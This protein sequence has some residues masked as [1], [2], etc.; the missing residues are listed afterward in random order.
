[1]AITLLVAELLPGLAAAQEEIRPPSGKGPLVVVLGGTGGNIRDVGVR[2]AALG[3]TV[4]VFDSNAIVA[5]KVSGA[6]R[7]VC[8][9]LFAAIAKARALPGIS[10]G[11]YG[12]VG[13]SLGGGLAFS[14][15]CPFPDPPSVIAAWYP[16]TNDLKNV[17][18]FASRIRIPTV[19]FAGTNDEYKFCC[20]I[21]K[22]REIANAAKAAGVPFELTEYKGAQHAFA[23]S[24]AAFHD[25]AST[26]DA[27]ART[28]AAL[29]KYLGN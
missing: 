24:T 12:I 2:I 6:P 16:V 17:P 28:A 1:V 7:P 23:Q 18:A 20:M 9:A 27:L 15:E 29:K 8:A 5:A 25:K 14:L 21:D 10:P 13:F 4:A 19:M 3:Y 11:N 26:D 22:A